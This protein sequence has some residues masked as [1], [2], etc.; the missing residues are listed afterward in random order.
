MEF[1]IDKQRWEEQATG[2]E[3]AQW[4]DTCFVNLKM[5]AGPQYPPMERHGALAHVCDLSA[6]GGQ[7]RW[8]P[9]ALWLAS[10]AKTASCRV[11]EK[12]CLKN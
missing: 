2:C 10:L 11:S 3:R 6:D 5:S 8:I 1:A 7:D 12:P 4:V 9:G